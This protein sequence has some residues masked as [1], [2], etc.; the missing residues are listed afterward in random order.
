MTQEMFIYVFLTIMKNGYRDVVGREYIFI[1]QFRGLQR[2]KVLEKPVWNGRCG[3]SV[4]FTV[5]LFVL[6]C[7]GG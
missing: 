1:L 2:L 5:K 7:Y 6:G 3:T 4:A